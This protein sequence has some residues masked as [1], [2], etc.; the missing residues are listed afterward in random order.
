MTHGR[1]KQRPSG[2]GGPC[3]LEQVQDEAFQ[4]VVKVVAAPQ[5]Q[6]AQRGGALSHEGHGG[7]AASETSLDGASHLV[8][9][10]EDVS[11]RVQDVQPLGFP[12]MGDHVLQPQ[13]A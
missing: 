13:E 2:L 8:G 12:L 7:P 6:G 5:S 1:T 4:M 9:M 10:G 11:V 3:P